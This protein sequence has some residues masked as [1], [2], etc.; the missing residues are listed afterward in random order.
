MTNKL[1]AFKEP[2]VSLQ[3]QQK[4]AVGTYPEPVKS[5]PHLNILFY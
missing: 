4:R 2:E 5:S 1:S 3:S